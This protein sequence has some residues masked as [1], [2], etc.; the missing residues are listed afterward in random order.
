MI[1]KQS[2]AANL[3]VLMVGSSDHIT[4]LTGATLTITASKDGGAFSAITPTVT[5]LATGWYSLAL[6][7]AHTDT[8]GALV[9]H[10]TA[11]SADPA[12]VLAQVVGYDPS[13]P[14]DKLLRNK[15]KT[16]PVTGVMTVYDDDGTT[17]LYTANIY[18]DAA[19]TVPYAGSGA[20]LRNRLV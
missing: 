9:L 12:D 17:V 10:I 18:Q 6:T 20:E 1:L 13:V 2:T 16:D 5:E 8:T 15:T 19:G 4:G 14:I 11:A 3:P 7:A